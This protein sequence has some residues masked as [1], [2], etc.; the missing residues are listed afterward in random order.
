M[1]SIFTVLISIIKLAGKKTDSKQLDFYERLPPV[2]PLWYYKLTTKEV[3]GWKQCIRN[4]TIVRKLNM[5]EKGDFLLFLDVAIHM[6]RKTLPPSSKTTQ[7][8]AKL[9]KT[10]WTHSPLCG[11]HKWMIPYNNSTPFL[12]FISEAFRHARIV[13]DKCIMLCDKS[14][15]TIYYLL[16]C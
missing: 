1:H 14:D 8:S 6:I 12:H 3:W 16:Y 11:R 2:S 4:Q 10:S 5:M 13:T 9:L 15:E 7:S